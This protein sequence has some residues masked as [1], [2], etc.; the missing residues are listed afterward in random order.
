MAAAASHVPPGAWTARY[1]GR[2]VQEPGANVTT[3]MPILRGGR[4]RGGRRPGMIVRA[5]FEPRTAA[6]ER[7]TAYMAGIL[8]LEHRVQEA[9]SQT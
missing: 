3:Y 9:Q 4:I 5:Q 7:R 6:A 2:Y 1:L 8:P